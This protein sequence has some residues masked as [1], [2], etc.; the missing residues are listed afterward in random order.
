MTIYDLINGYQD[1][2]LKLQ[3]I[4]MQHPGSYLFLKHVDAEVEKLIVPLTQLRTHI[5]SVSP[6]DRSLAKAWIQDHQQSLDDVC[7]SCEA[8]VTVLASQI[9]G[10]RI[11]G[12]LK[13]IPFAL[14]FKYLFAKYIMN[15]QARPLQQHRVALESLLQKYG[16]SDRINLK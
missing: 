10:L 4:L 12:I 8:I 3:S 9:D 1:L 16:Y 5:D 13:W 14:K 7:S 11:I 6:I 15:W 2:A